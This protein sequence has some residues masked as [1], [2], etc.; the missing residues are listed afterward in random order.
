MPRRRRRDRERVR[1]LLRRPGDAQCTMLSGT[2]LS[3][4]LI[5]MT[6]VLGGIVAFLLLSQV[7]RGWLEGVIQ[8]LVLSVQARAVS[9]HQ[10]GA[11]VGLR[12][13]GQRLTSIAVPPIMGGIADRWGVTRKLL[14]S[15][16]AHVAAVRAARAHRPPRR[17]AS[18]RRQ[19]SGR[20]RDRLK[21]LLAIT[22]AS[23]NAKMAADPGARG[24]A[25]DHQPVC[26]GR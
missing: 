24:V 8:P 1:C 4:L 3:I 7:I 16:R 26:F 23:P 18:I 12:Q 10:Q 20:R 6:P 11:V 5:A 13:T 17:A 2:A 9:R 25:P 21:P 22:L 15:R 19:A 14:C